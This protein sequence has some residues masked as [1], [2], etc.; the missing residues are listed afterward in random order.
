[1]V[2]LCIIMTFTVSIVTNVHTWPDPSF[3]AIQHTLGSK[4]F[5]MMEIVT[6]N[7]P[8]SNGKTENS[9]LGGVLKLRC[10]FILFCRCND[11]VTVILVWLLIMN[12]PFIWWVFCIP[13]PIRMLL[14]CIL[15]SARLCVLSRQ[16]Q[17]FS[18]QV[19]CFLHVQGDGFQR[20]QVFSKG[21]QSK[22]VFIQ[23]SRAQLLDMTPR[24]TPDL[25]SYLRSLQIGI[26]LSRKR[27]RHWGRRKQKQSKQGSHFP[28]L[29]LTLTERLISKD[30]DLVEDS[31]SDISVWITSHVNHT[32]TICQSGVN[33]SNLISSTTQDSHE[34][35]HQCNGAVEWSKD[36]TQAAESVKMET[37]AGIWQTGFILQQQTVF[38]HTQN[39]HAH[40]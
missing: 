9:L 24:L 40:A 31:R 11:Y 2:F 28:P 13:L 19:T 4:P 7:I 5:L 30:Q 25:V 37:T 16:C 32:P 6:W 15:F 14:L 8:L 17:P 36:R 1:M 35:T 21:E 29:S 22:C 38:Q 18:L 10:V 23:Y 26:D 3:D 20:G 39:L 33:F 34:S 27:S 12:G